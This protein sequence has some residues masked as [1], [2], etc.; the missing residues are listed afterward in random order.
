[1]TSTLNTNSSTVPTVGG[2]I[3]APP[4]NSAGTT[5]HPHNV[6]V[7]AKPKLA[8]QKL[9][10]LLRQMKT[11]QQLL[12]QAMADDAA[13]DILSLL[14]PFPKPKEGISVGNVDAKK[15]QDAKVSSGDFEI[16]DYIQFGKQSHVGRVLG[17]KGTAP[18]SEYVFRAEGT[19]V[20]VQAPFR[21]L[22][23][24]TPLIV[25]PV[26][27]YKSR[28]ANELHFA[29]MRIDY[30]FGLLVKP[31]FQLLASM[32]KSLKVGHKLWNLNAQNCLWVMTEYTVESINT[33]R[34]S[35]R[36]VLKHRNGT[37]STVNI[38]WAE[39]AVEK[40]EFFPSCSQTLEDPSLDDIA[41][42][43]LW[44]NIFRDAPTFIIE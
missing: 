18:L 40:I 31:A 36:Y 38:S 7:H 14:P 8:L 2:Q 6:D 22:W 16:G 3:S 20:L 39:C 12:K 4:A 24:C 30:Q 9:L 27:P 1:M 37:L 42:L 41:C 28:K 43:Q 17:F 29:S 23:H 32:G 26:G 25:L 44:M 33:S 10:E 35:N 13:D 15:A 19:G 11:I 5:D 34:D 21:D